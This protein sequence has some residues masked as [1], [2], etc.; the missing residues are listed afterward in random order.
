MELHIKNKHIIFFLV[1]RCK[2][3]QHN[4]NFIDCIPYPG[5]SCNFKCKPRYQI[6]VNTTVSCGPAGQWIPSID[7]LCK[8]TFENFILKSTIDRFDMNKCI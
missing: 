4:L 2:T 6:A 5:Q 7:T 3:L 8:G 1:V